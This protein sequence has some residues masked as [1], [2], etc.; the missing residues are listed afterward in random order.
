M[1]ASLREPSAIFKVVCDL[2]GRWAS[3]GLRA[4][5][6]TITAPRGVY[7]NDGIDLDSSSGAR[8][9]NLYYDG[10]DDGVALKSGLA[11]EGDVVGLLADRRDAARGQQLAR[12]ATAV[13]SGPAWVL[14]Y[15]V[16]HH[17]Q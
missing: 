13:W 11:E 1:A 8:V 5:N 4:A 17:L 3:A 12:A 15:S 9:E 16:G 7:N 10:G 14:P 2:S 6:L